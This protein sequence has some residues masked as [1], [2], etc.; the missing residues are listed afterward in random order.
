MKK[1]IITK[2]VSILGLIVAGT[3]YAQSNENYVQSITCLTHDCTKTSQTI[4]YFDGLGR[5]KQLINVKA[6]PTGKDLVT[7]V[8]YDGFG[9]QAKNILPV[10]VATQNSNIHSGITNEATANSYYGVSNAYAE[11][12]IENSPLDRVLQ[13]AQAGEAWKL[14]SGH[15]KKFKY[16]ANTANEV[17]KFVVTTSII[18]ANNV[19][20]TS[21]SLK[22]SSENSGYYP[23]GVLYKNTVSDEDGSPVIQFQNG[24]GQTLLIRKTDGTQNIDTYY[25]YNEYNQLAY[26]IPPKAVQQIEQGGNIV[27][28]IILQDLCYQYN[29]DGRNREVE[30]KLPGKDWEFTVYDKQDRPVLSQD[31]YLRTTT[32]HFGSRGW[33][34]TKYDEF[35]RVVYTGFFSNTATRRVMQSALNSMSANAYNNE[36]RST[37]SFNQQG[38]NVYYD[39]QAFPTGSMTLLSVNYYDT[40]PPEAPA[41]PTTI[42]GQYT[43]P[44]TLGANDDASTNS[45]QTASYMKNI[46]DNNWTKT[47]NYYDSMGRL[48]STNT[49]N[50]LGGYTNKEFKLGFTGQ[51]DESYTAHKRRATDAEVKVKERFVYD[52]QNRLLKQYHQV[53]TNTEELLAENTYNE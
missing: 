14:S 7:A 29:Y 48:I 38:I 17:K 2:V 43:L 28:T 26:I 45:L 47:Y 36:K 11:Q 41:V 27:T 18:T 19:S 31:G 40:Y 12:E 20:G 22:V 3:S 35:G 53:D 46:E 50:H 51:T 25:A 15:T 49:I 30:K 5:A 42:L 6:T 52:N 9:R 8:T 10:P 37:S 34:F 13:Q 1:Y 21:S 32:N 4:T 16:E 24:N 33:I 23:A 39:K 44:Q